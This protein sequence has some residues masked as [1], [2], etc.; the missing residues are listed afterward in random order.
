MA[1]YQYFSTKGKAKPMRQKPQL[2]KTNAEKP[3]SLKKVLWDIIVE[4]IIDR[5]GLNK[6][7]IHLS[8][9]LWSD[10]EA[11]TLDIGEILVDLEQKFNADISN[12][13]KR[14]WSNELNEYYFYRGKDLCRDITNE[15]GVTHDSYLTVGHV[16]EYTVRRFGANLMFRLAKQGD[17]DDVRHLVHEV[18]SLAEKKDAYGTT[19]LMHAVKNG[20]LKM[21]HDLLALKIDTDSQNEN[22]STALVFAIAKEHT[23]IV[24]A[25]I[26]AGSDFNIAPKMDL[27]PLMM[28]SIKGNVR[29]VN[30][31]IEAAVNVNAKNRYGITSFINT[32]NKYRR[33]ALMYAIAGGHVSIVQ[34]LLSNGA[35]PNAID[36]YGNK[37]LAIAKHEKNDELAQLLIKAGASDAKHS[38]TVHVGKE[39]MLHSPCITCGKSWPTMSEAR[40]IMG[41]SVSGSIEM[42]PSSA[43]KSGYGLTCGE[44]VVSFCAKHLE[45]VTCPWCG[46]IMQ[47]L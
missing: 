12:R 44:C 43:L 15:L 11:D 17:W 46:E 24:Q 7:K 39:R 4:V 16:Y 13:N 28:A 41:L 40:G 34:M 3:Q 19:I 27:T 38:P 42:E 21:V 20:N 10:L 25:L 29:I 32:K 14:E 36:K 5:L 31:L 1:L 9:N 6:S 8:S 23:E 26:E 30:S 22:G 45:E 33:T 35:D 18:K 47:Y 37:P 2:A